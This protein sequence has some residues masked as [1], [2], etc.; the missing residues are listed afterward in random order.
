MARTS[1]ISASS[2]ERRPAVSMMTTSRPSRVASF[3]PV[4]RDVD[5]RT[6][7]G[8]DVDADLGAQHAQLLDGRRSLK[9]GRDEVRLATLLLEPVG[10]LRRGRRLTRALETGEQDDRRGLARRR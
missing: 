10:E 6:R 4:L 2:I 5:G 8:E 9:V 1:S 7:L 3:E